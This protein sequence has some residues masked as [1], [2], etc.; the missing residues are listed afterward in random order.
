MLTQ[1]HDTSSL[2]V[3]STAATRSFLAQSAG[4]SQRCSTL[5]TDVR[6][7]AESAHSLQEILRIEK[8]PREVPFIPPH[9][10]VFLSVR[11]VAFGESTRAETRHTLS[12]TNALIARIGR[13][14]ISAH[15]VRQHSRANWISGVYVRPLQSTCLR[16]STRSSHQL[17]RKYS[18]SRRYSCDPECPA[19]P[20][21]LRL[22]AAWPECM[23]RKLR[24]CLYRGLSSVRTSAKA[25]CQHSPRAK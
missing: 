12:G 17:L 25:A 20:H 22:R 23:V 6:S 21:I 24:N 8:N 1:V 14:R 18:G 19:K 11:A 13:V 5:T 15:A 2:V 3:L 16:A 7:R 4:R 10:F 9:G